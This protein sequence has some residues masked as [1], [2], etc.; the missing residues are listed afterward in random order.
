[1]NAFYFH[2]TK[3]DKKKSVSISASLEAQHNEGCSVAIRRANTPPEGHNAS[4]GP[5]RLRKW[6]GRK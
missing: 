4:A 1:M 3:D 6:R 2:L 5:Q